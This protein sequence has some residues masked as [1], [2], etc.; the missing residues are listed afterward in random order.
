MKIF[1][2]VF[3]VLV[4]PLLAFTTVHKYYISV[5][6][7]AYSEKDEAIQITSRVFVDD[8]NAVLEE[9]YGIKTEFGSEKESDIANEY[10]EKYFKTKFT[11]GINDSIMDYKFLGKKYEDDLMVCYI[12]VSSIKLS[13]LKT[14]EIQNEVLMDMYSDQQNIVHIKLKGKKKSMI[15]IKENDKGMLNL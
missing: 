13:K 4:L 8:M 9:R 6:N 11:I 14:I 3:L 5:T 10:L 15:L 7:I 2:K 12:E 1:K